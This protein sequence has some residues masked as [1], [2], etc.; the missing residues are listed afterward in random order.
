MLSRRDVLQRASLVLGY[1]VTGTAAASVLGG[2]ARSPRLDWT[3]AVFTP[4]QAVTVRAMVDHLLPRTTTPGAADLNV[5]RYI[6]AALKDYAT[7]DDR[8]TFSTG[9]ADLDAQCQASFGARFLDLPPAQ[10]DDLFRRYE[11]ASPGLPPT[12]W[13]G[14]ITAVVERPTFYRQFKQLALVGYFL[15]EE[16][17]EKLLAY[18]PIPGRF[19]ACIPVSQVGKAWS[20]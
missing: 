5:E 8:Q 2:C 14:Q 13:G 18:D 20:L 1:A 19:D 3:P 6:D 16:V 17:G 4:E 12:V 9:L 15:S 10:R 11:A 7:D